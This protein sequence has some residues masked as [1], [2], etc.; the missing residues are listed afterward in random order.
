MLEERNLEVFCRSLKEKEKENLR[1][2]KLAKLQKKMRWK[3]FV[4]MDSQRYF[5]LVTNQKNKTKTKQNKK[6]TSPRPLSLV[7]SHPNE[8]P[9]YFC[10]DNLENDHEALSSARLAGSRTATMIPADSLLF[11]LFSFDFF[12]L[13]LFFGSFKSNLPIPFLSSVRP[14][15][16]RLSGGSQA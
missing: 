9:E 2:Q 5:G 4:F 6:S 10:H 16:R 11:L 14:S 1:L 12:F 13:F 7:S 8:K 15:R 3:L